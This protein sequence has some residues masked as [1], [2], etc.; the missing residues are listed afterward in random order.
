MTTNKLP[1][2]KVGDQIYVPSSMSFDRGESDIRGGLGTISGI[3]EYFSNQFISIEECPEHSWNVKI[4]LEEQGDLKKEFG[5]KTARPDPDYGNNTKK[6]ITQIAIER[7]D[8]NLQA[9][10]DV[11]AS[12]YT[13]PE[14]FDEAD[15]QAIKAMKLGLIRLQNKLLPK[16]KQKTT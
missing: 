3:E 16:S 9:L 4:L 1:N 14:I 5:K 11:A 12:I 10:T 6:K 2:P 8:T 7:I 15:K 13:S